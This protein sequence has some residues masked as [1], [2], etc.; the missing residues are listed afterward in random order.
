MPAAEW[1]DQGLMLDKGGFV[2][3]D[4]SLSDVVLLDPAF[5]DREP[6]PYETSGP[7]V[8]PA[9]CARAR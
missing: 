2:L 5:G 3:I 9:T 4:Q 6:F 7:S 1:L 8:V